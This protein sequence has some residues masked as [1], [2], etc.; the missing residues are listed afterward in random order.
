MEWGGR[1]EGTFEEVGDCGVAGFV[2]G[3]RMGR[4]G[5]TGDGEGGEGG[6]EDD[7]WQEEGFHGG[8]PQ[9]RFVVRGD[10]YVMEEVTKYLAFCFL[11]SSDV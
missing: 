5:M 1:I 8:C 3:E 10:E 11:A 7:G 2:G 9:R 6:E 4:W